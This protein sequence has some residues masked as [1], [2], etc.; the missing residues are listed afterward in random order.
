M[1]LT[2]VAKESLVV[3]ATLNASTLKAP[4]SALAREATPEILPD[5]FKCPAC[6]PME[7]SV[8]ETLHANMLEEIA[9]GMSWRHKSP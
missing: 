9:I 5:V 7:Q 8:I 2:N 4:T 1:T 6:V 3:V